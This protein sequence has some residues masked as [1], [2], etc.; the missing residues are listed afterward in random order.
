MQTKWNEV[1]DLS[2]VDKVGCTCFR[3]CNQAQGC[4]TLSHAGLV[5]KNEPEGAQQIIAAYAENK[6]KMGGGQE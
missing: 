6:K 1:T 3:A 5:I 4:V 2:K